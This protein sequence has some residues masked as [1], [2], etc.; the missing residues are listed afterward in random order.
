MSF[1]DELEKIRA[2]IAS[3]LDIDE[4]VIL[5]SECNWCGA[6][7]GTLL[8]TSDERLVFVLEKGWFTKRYEKNRWYWI[9]QI[10]NVRLED[11]WGGKKMIM[12][13]LSN[14][15]IVRIEF[16]GLS[17]P[18][19]WRDYLIEKIKGFRVSDRVNDEISRLVSSNEYT[20][21]RA[22]FD[23]AKK[24]YPYEPGTYEENISF[25]ISRLEDLLEAGRIDGFIDRENR[26]FIH[27]VAYL[28]KTEVTNYNIATEFKFDGSSFFIKCPGCG[29]ES[30]SQK[31]SEVTCSSC[32]QTYRVPQK[33]LDRI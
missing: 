16:N 9:R 10:H 14:D 19:R 32:G 27:K 21:F 1:E 25:V 3:V 6:L 28:Q 18:E 13:Y 33:L 8:A 5:Q 15:N 12:E 4:T 30:P 23:D 11:T 29:A 31:S 24:E 7:D 17:N 22:I 2:G 26:Q 20:S